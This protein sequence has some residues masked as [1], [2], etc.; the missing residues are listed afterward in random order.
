MIGVDKSRQI[1]QNVR[2]TPMASVWN[3]TARTVLNSLISKHFPVASGVRN[4]VEDSVNSSFRIFIK[5]TI[6]KNSHDIN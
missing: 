4:P 1:E 2:L 3:N 5:D 6:L